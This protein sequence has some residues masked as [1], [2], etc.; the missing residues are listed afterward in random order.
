M[1]AK[2]IPGILPELTEEESLEITKIYSVSGKRKEAA[3]LVKKRPFRAP[4]HSATI[5]ALVGGGRRPIPGEIS[6]SSNGVLFLDE[7]PEFGRSVIEALRQPLEEKKITIDRIT[8]KSTYPADFMLVAAMNVTLTS[9]IQ[10][11]CSQW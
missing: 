7:L 1:L 5:T 8:S 10:K 2:R 9:V 11:Q 3:A 4:H 6:L